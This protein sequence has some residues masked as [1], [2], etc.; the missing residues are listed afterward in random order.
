MSNQGDLK[1]YRWPP[2]NDWAQASCFFFFF[3]SFNSWFQSAFKKS[4]LRW[5]SSGRL[6]FLCLFTIIVMQLSAQ[7]PEG[8]KSSNW[9]RGV[10][11]YCFPVRFKK[12]PIWFVI[13]PPPVPPPFSSTQSMESQEECCIKSDQQW[14]QKTSTKAKGPSPAKL[15]PL[16]IQCPCLPHAA[17][18]FQLN[19]CPPAKPGMPGTVTFSPT[20]P[21][22]VSQED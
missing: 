7:G 21:T 3:K 14:Q 17:P 22:L 18:P 20:S 9:L 19:P 4:F 15:P 6:C 5:L 13:F 16:D 12:K 10:A 2:W 1:Y 8:H 11:L